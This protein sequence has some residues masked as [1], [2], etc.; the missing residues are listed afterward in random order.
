MGMDM[1]ELAGRI[2]VGPRVRT[3]YALPDTSV[4]HTWR[5]HGGRAGFVKDAR[6][7]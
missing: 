7:R 5:E 3:S 2:V 4:D 1:G 6:D